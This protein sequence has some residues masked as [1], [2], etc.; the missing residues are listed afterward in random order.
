MTVAITEGIT[1]ATESETQLALRQQI[2]R[3]ESNLSS[4]R[5]GSARFRE[6]VKNEVEA[7]VEGEVL[8]L[9]SA[10]EFLA[11]LGLPRIS[12]EVEVE[13][14]IRGTMTVDATKLRDP[15]N[16]YSYDLEANVDIYAS[17][18]CEAEVTDVSHYGLS[19][20]SINA[21]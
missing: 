18:G 15:H 19:I 4:V 1:P 10:N 16:S 7:L 12:T 13:F 17:Y 14:V 21:L 5:A 6:S 2:E 11:T 8:D 9:D 20:E 3:L